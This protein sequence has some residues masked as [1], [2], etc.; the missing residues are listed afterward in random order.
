MKKILIV[1]LCI[2]LFSNGQRVILSSPTPISQDETAMCVSFSMS[3][4]FTI[5][6]NKDHKN[7][8]DEEKINKIRMSP[9]FLYYLFKQ[10]KDSCSRT[11]GLNV[12]SDKMWDFVREFGLPF[13]SDIEENYFFPYGESMICFYYP[14]SR[15]DIVNDIRKGAK[16]RIKRYQGG[17]CGETENTWCMPDF[18]VNK[19]KLKNELKNGRPCFIFGTNVCP[20]LTD[21]G[22]SLVE[23]C[24]FGGGH[25]MVI[26]GYDDNKHGGSY[27]IQD[28]YLEKSSND[29]PKGRH[30]VRYQD[31]DT[32][33][34]GKIFSIDGDIIYEQLSYEDINGYLKDIYPDTTRKFMY[35]DAITKEPLELTAL[36]KKIEIWRDKCELIYDSYEYCDCLFNRLEIENDDVFEGIVSNS[37]YTKNKDFKFLLEE[38]YNEIDDRNLMLEYCK[39]DTV[40]IGCVMGDCFKGYGKK[41]WKHKKRR[42]Y[43][44]N[45]KDNKFHGDGRL[46]LKNGDVWDGKWKNG[47]KH[48]KFNFTRNGVTKKKKCKN[49][50]CK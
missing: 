23:S 16:Y 8:D 2:P 28:S 4:I 17:M 12:E 24:G 20:K 44:G 19:D 1:L 3:T 27:L 18:Y 14:Y 11:G 22:Y 25:A 36:G 32:I 33:S 38:I 21:G 5:L 39:E 6:Y 48:G 15:D 30:W 41:V 45:W 43:I 7:F 13:S 34:G 49:N 10:E 29:L 40:M 9:T 42:S 47:I 50:K 26:I 35:K 37:Y 31:L 46:T